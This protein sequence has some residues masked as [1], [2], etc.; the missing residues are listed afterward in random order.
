[1]RGIRIRL[2]RARSFGAFIVA[3]VVGGVAFVT[4]I[5][6]WV[7]RIG[8]VGLAVIGALVLVLFVVGVALPEPVWERLRADTEAQARAAT[9]QAVS[10][11]ITASDDLR[12]RF[13]KE[14]PD[15]NDMTAAVAEWW[16]DTLAEVAEHAPE[17]SVELEMSASEPIRDYI[18]MT[19]EQ[20]GILSK[21]DVRRDRLPKI[22]EG[23]RTR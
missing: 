7:E 11:C 12:R 4:A 1:V 20:P 15:A 16:K 21:F 8:V 10:G 23:L 13:L 5:A 22:L 3:F 17:Y 18:G 9:I 19:K 14:K 2:L 6:Y